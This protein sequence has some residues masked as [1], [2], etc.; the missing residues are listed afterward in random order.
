MRWKIQ[1]RDHTGEPK[2]DQTEDARGIEWTRRC[3]GLTGQVAADEGSLTADELEKS[4][5]KS[6]H[7]GLRRRYNDRREEL[8]GGA[9]SLREV[10]ESVTMGEDH[11]DIYFGEFQ[12]AR[13]P[14]GEYYKIT[15]PGAHRERDAPI[16]VDQEF[17]SDY[18]NT[19]TVGGD[20]GC[21]TISGTKICSSVSAGFKVT[22]TSAVEVSG[23]LFMDVVISSGNAE[24]TLG[25]AGLSFAIGP[26][27]YDGFCLDAGTKLPGK[28]PAGSLEICGEVGFETRNGGEEARISLGVGGGD[29][30]VNLCSPLDCSVCATL[31]KV[32]GTYKTEWF[33]NPLQ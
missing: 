10:D 12:N 24:V 29:I 13:A 4:L 6:R 30:C 11:P 33:D 8:L 9:D 21:A 22:G 23:S 26:G 2:N 19:F 20:I 14:S 7:V 15:E 16:T 32:G 28:L 25:L 17:R 3:G 31:V 18:L 27:K 1:Q 5:R